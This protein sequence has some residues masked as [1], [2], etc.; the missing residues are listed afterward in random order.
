MLRTPCLSILLTAGMLGF[1]SVPTKAAIRLEGQVQAGGGPVSNSTVILWGEHRQQRN[2]GLGQDRVAPLTGDEVKEARNV[3]MGGGSFSSASWPGGP[4]PGGNVGEI[5]YPP[6]VL[7]GG[8]GGG[9]RRYRS[10]SQGYAR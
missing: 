2:R 5:Y 10:S 1:A 9:H 4:A 3:A 8:R 7:G 6:G